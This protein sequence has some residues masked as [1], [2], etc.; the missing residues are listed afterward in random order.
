[1]PVPT[2]S[3]LNAV[4]KANDL[5]EFLDT[6]GWE[7]VVLPMLEKTKADLA[8]QLAQATLDPAPQARNTSLVYAAKIEAVN[9]IR[10]EFEKILRQGI[11]AHTALITSDNFLD[12]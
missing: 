9:W 11:H 5:K 2:Q 7:A 8:A 1:M 10:I 3:Q 12:S 6:I 4:A